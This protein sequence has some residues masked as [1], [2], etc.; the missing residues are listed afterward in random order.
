MS[1]EE[2][3]SEE[4]FSSRSDV[5]SLGDDFDSIQSES[6]SSDEEVTNDEFN[7]NARGK[8]RTSWTWYFLVLLRTSVLLKS[9]SPLFPLGSIR[10]ISLE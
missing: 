8:K 9:R 3:D 4:S 2:T 7:S 10:L 1:F 6:E 5:S